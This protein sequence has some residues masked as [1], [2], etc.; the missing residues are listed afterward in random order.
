VVDK[1]INYRPEDG[2]IATNRQ[3]KKLQST[4]IQGT[5]S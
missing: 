3:N 4:T 1:T 5:F 2:M